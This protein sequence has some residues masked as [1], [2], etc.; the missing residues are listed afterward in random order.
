MKKSLLVWVA[1][2]CACHLCADSIG[3]SPLTLVQSVDLPNYSGDFDHFAVDLKKGRLFL[4]AE[5]HGTVEV[6]DIKSGKR[7]KTIDGF[8]APHS[9]LYMPEVDRLLVTD[10][11]KG[12]SKV[13]TGDDFRVVKT[14]RLTPG[15]DSIGFDRNAHQLYIVTGGKDAHLENS[16]LSIVDPV[17]G[18]HIGDIPF[19]ANHVEALAIEQSGRRL[20]INV[21]DKTYVAVVDRE[22]RQIV[23]KWPVN[24]CKQNSPIALDEGNHRLFVVCRQPGMLVVFD[25]S[26]G[27]SVA[28]LP[29][30]EKADDVVFDGQHHRIYV[31]G[32]EGYI[33]VY[34]QNSPDQ[35]ELLSRLPSAAG[36]KTALLVP[37]LKRLYVAVSPGEGKVGAK[38]LTFA[39]GD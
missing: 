18:G 14:L 19:A 11:G 36:A 31:P 33:G 27:K 15:A 23:D 29:A 30:P 2:L 39:V 5:D 26:T 1:V 4:A 25:T 34:R 35:Y 12:L 37:E 32:G 7:I 8:E 20:F 10:S 3:N 28:S 9:L 24:E 17:N 22:K 6:F 16:L 13:L 38:V 21:T